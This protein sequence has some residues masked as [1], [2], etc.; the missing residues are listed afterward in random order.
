MAEAKTS[1]IN[2]LSGEDPDT[3]E[4]NRRYQDA[5][6]KLTSSLDSR[7]NR[8]FDPTMLA[9]AEGF[10]SPTQT[11]GF[12]ESLGKVAGKLG[13]AEAAALKEEQELAQQKLAVAG[14]GIELQRMKA[15]DAEL[16]KYLNPTP[17]GPV[18]GPLAGAVAGP[19]A[20]PLSAPPAEGVEVTPLGA[21][22]QAAPLAEG[23]KVVGTPQGALAA[24]ES[25]KPPGFEGVQ[26]VQVM[27]PNPDFMTA[28]D[29][30][31][32]NRTNRSK[33]AADLIKEGQE[34]NAKRYRD[35]EGGVQD[36][37]TGMFYQFPTG[38]TEEIQI[39]GYP[40][41]HSVD[42]RTAA[43]LSL[44]AANNDP[45]YH[46]LAKRV[47]EGPRKKSDTKDDGT[48]PPTQ[49]KSKQDLAVEQKEAETRAGKLGEEG[50]KKEAAVSETASTARRVF[51][52]ATRVADLV[53][54]SPTYF[55]IFARPGITAAIGNLVK[56]GIQTPSGTLN[57]AG[58]ENS[59]RQ[60]MPG[61]TQ[62]DLDNVTKAATEL[63]ELELAFT[64]LYLAQQGAVTEG[65]RKIVRAI[66][67]TTSSSPEVLRTRM[68]L[69]KSRSQY[70]IDV[71]DAFRQWQDKNPGRSY[72]EF[73]R[74][75]DL[76]KD[77]KKDFEEQTERIFGGIKAVPTN[78]RQPKP[79]A[80]AA[81]GTQP[82]PGFIRD[83]KTGVIRRKK[84][85]E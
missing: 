7:K 34:I 26:G 33:S 79:A 9:M 61:V 71:A 24:L 5:L 57:I 31:R 1:T 40:G 47:M 76:Y 11:G 3:L 39:Y 35:R 50:A 78:Q 73:E 10:L 54:Q 52:N 58:F 46:D 49:R 80:P 21:L 59:M 13:P 27:P 60:M 14:Q 37:A 6:A 18:A 4:A 68:E 72:L 17:A 41:T 12:G 55:G 36:L 67:G 38:K 74:K 83:A 65:E 66:P 56:E 30:V 19:Q 28:R 75:S 70:D 64:R 45:E 43:R 25:N 62:K 44:L 22:S 32:L 81:G 53:N 63:A 20:G 77:I 69:L 29:Y 16:S 84:E 15:R 42:A 85:G 48:T 23:P 2:Y 8:F 51:G 82:S